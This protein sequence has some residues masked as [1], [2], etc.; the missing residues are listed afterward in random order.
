MPVE[1]LYC[2]SSCNLPRNYRGRDNECMEISVELT[3][4]R[5]VNN[6]KVDPIWISSRQ[7]D[8]SD[9]MVQTFGNSACSC[10]C[11]LFKHN[12][13]QN[14]TTEG[15]PPC[16]GVDGLFGWFDVQQQVLL[17]THSCLQLLLWVFSTRRGDHMGIPSALSCVGRCV[18][19]CLCVFRMGS[20][21]QR[22][23]VFLV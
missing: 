5:P 23:D 2:S 14:A 20:S 1:L 8:S 13:W 17:I 22:P 19:V 16:C 10:R 7:I 11:Y 15:S 9:T 21:S 3:Q 4:K 12:Q 6:P 18:C